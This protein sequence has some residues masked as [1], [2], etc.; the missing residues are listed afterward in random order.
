MYRLEFVKQKS[1]PVLA[2]RLSFFYRLVR[3]RSPVIRCEA[4][5]FRQSGLPASVVTAIVAV[6]AGFIHRFVYLEA[7]AVKFE[8]VGCSNSS[9]GFCIGT[10]FHK[11]KALGIARI[12]VGDNFYGF[13]ISIRGK[14]I[15][16]AVLE[17]VVREIADIKFFSHIWPTF[18]RIFRGFQNPPIQDKRFSR[19][20]SVSLHCRS[21]GQSEETD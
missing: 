9:L 5:S 21:P 11:A 8:T 12:T 4:A 16:E 2:D 18:A 3:S 17:G 13:N 10:H 19:L 14:E 6:P 15:A 1:L 7:A 20:I